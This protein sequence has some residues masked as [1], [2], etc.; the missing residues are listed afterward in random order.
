[1]LIWWNAPYL[2]GKPYTIL[3]SII[4]QAYALRRLLPTVLLIFDWGCKISNNLHR[5]EPCGGKYLSC[6]TFFRE[7]RKARTNSHKTSVGINPVL[8]SHCVGFNRST[9]GI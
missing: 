5:W 8:F 6:M 9:A 3:F 2:N 4:L 1:M 7:T